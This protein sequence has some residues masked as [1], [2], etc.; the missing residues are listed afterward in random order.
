M[1]GFDNSALVKK[2]SDA[3]KTMIDIAYNSK[4]AAHFGGGL[5]SVEILTYLFESFMNYDLSDKNSEN[6]DRFI[7]SKGHGVLSYYVVLHQAGFFSREKLNTFMLDESDLLSHP[8]KNHELGI[9]TSNG[10]LGQGLSY[11]AG[12]QIVAKR[13]EKNFRSIVLMGDGECNEGSVW[14]AAMCAGHYKLSNLIAVVDHNGLQ[15][16][17]RNDEILNMQEMLKNWKTIGW[18]VFEADGH[19]FE[20]LNRVFSTMDSE[21]GRPKLVIAHT[22]KGKG[23]SFMENN[24]VWHHEP[25]NEEMYNKAIEELN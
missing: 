10:S 23:V 18:D 5:S 21:N 13:T 15:S 22:V 20:D 7:L 24:N 12:Q 11:A 9:E 16:D 1:T 14:E 25:L 17:G 6:R 19:S 8:V 3:R 2:A 4:Q